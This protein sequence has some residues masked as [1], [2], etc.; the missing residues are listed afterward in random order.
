MRKSYLDNIRWAVVVLVVIYHVFYMYNGEGIL[1]VVGKITDLPVQYYD[2]YMYMVYPW[3]MSV[4]FIVAG[5]SSRYWFDSHSGQVADPG[6]EREA[7]SGS[8]HN[9]LDSSDRDF[10]KSRTTKLLVPCTVGLLVFGFLQGFVVFLAIPI[11]WSAPFGGLPIVGAV[12]ALALWLFLLHILVLCGFRATV[13]LDQALLR[14]RTASDA[15]PDG[16]TPPS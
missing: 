4:L 1:G 12:L 13:V 15:P 9:F 16:E 2:V 6:S 11:E 8:R 14:R 10:I 5:A 3:V 7:D